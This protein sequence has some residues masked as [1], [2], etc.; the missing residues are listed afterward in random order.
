[1]TDHSTADGTIG[2]RLRAAR[3]GRGLT[4]EALAERSGVSIELI[5]KLERGKR[6]T[7]RITTL[8]S[9]SNALGVPLS[10]LLG[11][12]ER[13]DRAASAGVLAVRDALLSVTDLPGIDP[14]AD[15]GDPTPV[16]DLAAAVRR[17]WNLYWA[18]EL[19]ALA[20]MLPGLIGEARLARDHA[21]PRAAQPLAQAYQLAADLMVHV[22]NDDLAMVAAERAIA[23]AAAGDDELQH[24]TLLGTA[25]WVLLHQGRTGDAEKVAVSAAEK[26]EPR[27]SS[28]TPEHL[29]VWGSLL[30]SAAA[31]AATA[32]RAADVD[33]Y[34][35]LARS[36]A[37]P[38]EGD[39]HDYWVSFG[40]TQVAM[41]TTYA[42]AVLGRPGTALEAAK[43]V[44]RA[45]LLDLSW[46]A[47]H[48]DVAQ[49]LATD[50]RARDDKKAVEALQVAHGVS[51]EW[52]RHQGLA[53]SLT[54]ELAHRKTRLGE[55]LG[56]LMA[57]IGAED[58]A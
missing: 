41:Q 19:G 8:T 48:L 18:G 33:T 51:R 21:G 31:P 26:I 4:Q 17:G 52:F 49:A 24:A 20:G 12:R 27:M 43:G 53:R 2:S 58:A 29:T 11:R 38:F 37:G 6:E 1:M 47:H 54:L 15:H 42:N 50:G 7:A 34:L 40:P 14:A 32:S 36:A 30:L 45:D 5:G 46:G 44:R 25:S 28:A 3:R 57:A 56:M 22:G 16:P 23:V 35:G 9:L 10:A 39:R 55:P 13:L